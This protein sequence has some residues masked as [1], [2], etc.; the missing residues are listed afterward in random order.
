MPN[1]DVSPDSKVHGVNMGLS[2]VL[3]AP[4][5]PHVGPMNLAIR[6][7]TMVS[8]ISQQP[9]TTTMG[10][11]EE[12]QIWQNKTICST[13]FSRGQ[14]T[15]LHCFDCGGCHSIRGDCTCCLFDQWWVSTTTQI[16]PICTHHHPT[17]SVMSSCAYINGYD[18]NA[19]NISKS[20][21]NVIHVSF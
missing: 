5:G 13:R 2:W 16:H 15:I 12:D 11:R 9:H 18:T 3:S 10:W 7:C 6:A 17:D 20:Q 4:D 14:F 1:C 8:F 19:I 21:H